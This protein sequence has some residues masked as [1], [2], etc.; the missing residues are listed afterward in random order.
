MIFLKQITHKYIKKNKTNF[1]NNK[2]RII[3]KNKDYK[4]Y[5]I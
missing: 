1:I 5:L 4:M 3:N 2:I